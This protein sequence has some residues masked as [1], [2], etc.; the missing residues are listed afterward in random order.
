MTSQASCIKGEAGDDEIRAQDN[1][2]DTLNGGEGNDSAERDDPLDLF[3]SI[4]NAT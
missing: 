3:Q 4:E 2:A 1:V